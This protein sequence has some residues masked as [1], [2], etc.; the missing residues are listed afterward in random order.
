M[1]KKILVLLIILFSISGASA[2]YDPDWDYRIPVTLDN[3]G[4]VSLATHRFDVSIPAGINESSIR[5]V[6]DTSGNVVSHWAENVSSGVC[7]GLWFNGSVDSGVSEDYYIYYGNDGVASTSSYNDTF[8][9]GIVLDVPLTTRYADGNTMIDRSPYGNNGTNYGATVGADS[10]EFNGSSDYVNHGRPGS[11]TSNNISITVWLYS[12]TN[13][14]PA[15]TSALQRRGD[16]FRLGYRVTSG[17]IEFRFAIEK[18]DT[19]IIYPWLST[20]ISGVGSWHMYTITYNGEIIKVYR[21][22]GYVTQYTQTGEGVAFYT[23]VDGNFYISDPNFNFNGSISDTRIYNRALTPTQITSLYEQHNTT[24]TVTLESP[25]SSDVFVSVWNTSLTSVGSSINTSVALPLELGGTYNFD[26]YWGD[27]SFDTITSY[28][29][30]EVTHV[31]ASQGEYE[32][33]IDGT[34]NGFRFNNAGDRLKLINVTNWGNLKIGDSNGY[35]YGCNNLVITA[36]DVLYLNDTTTLF[37]AFRACSLITSIPNANDWNMSS[38]TNM[39]YVFSYA[40]LFDQDIGSWDVSSVTSMD[41]TFR[42]AETFNQD[43]GS[44]DVSNVTTMSNMFRNALA[45]DRDIG[46]WDVS[47]VTAMAYMFKYAALSTINYNSLL[48]GWE[49]LPVQNNVVFHGGYSKYSCGIVART[50]LIDDH[51]W[52]ITDGGGEVST[53]NISLYS[54]SPAT[55]FT[56]Y[57]GFLSASYMVDSNYFL[58]F[59]SLAFLMGVNYTLTSDYHSYL[60]VPPNSI[61]SDGI[62]RAHNR[63]TSPYMTWES[64]S[65]ITEGNVWKW[66]GGVNEDHWIV[67]KSVNVTHTWVNVTGVASNVFPAMFYLDRAAMY[68][69]E[70]TGIEINKGQGIILK[71]WDLE[72]FRSRNYDYYLSMFFDTQME[73]DTNCNID[74]WYCNDSF[75]PNTD[76]PCLACDYKDSWSQARWTD[77]Q[78]WQPHNNVSYSNPLQIHAG[79]VTCPS[80][81]T[82]VNYIYLQSDTVSSKS[83]I[84]NATNTDPNTCNLTFAQTNTMWTRNEVLGTN[85]P[86]AYTPSFFNTFTRDYLEFTHHLYIANDQGTWGHSDYATH[87]IGISD[88]A[89]TFCRFNYFHWNGTYD[90]C[91][92]GTYEKDFIINLTYGFDPD[93]GASL[94]HILSLY[95]DDYNFI[96]IINSSLTGNQ[97]DVNIFFDIDDYISKYLSGRYR[98]KI[99]STDNEGSTSVSWSNEFSIKRDSWFKNIVSTLTGFPSIASSILSSFLGYLPLFVGVLISGFLI[100]VCVGVFGKLKRW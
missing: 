40:T 46:P 29:Q 87:E 62:Y 68:E 64:N 25:E 49:S 27:G 93:N 65:T 76:D 20:G 51:F 35:F 79:T 58:N 98:F 8:G 39:E 82:E 67:N 23:L 31:Y 34:L 19:T 77:H 56:N 63:N 96:A 36:T 12:N 95:D 97:S 28:N 85:S 22:E 69:S 53:I 57:T 89:P 24:P 84:L 42:Y 94:T 59:S 70:K 83:F 71:V 30:A 91:M 38:V 73:A 13:N 81:P 44:W 100:M 2:W 99:V 33:V 18:P 17:N 15:K 54:K 48:M 88:I 90:Y 4:N 47:G 7:Y 21:D 26:V 60:K 32:I 6:N 37:N 74:I 16:A 92:N 66:A 50:A 43:I 86:L 45:F 3:T 9:D 55:L 1:F 78:A 10:S 72:Q 5:V 80:S 75:N 14:V 41:S 11:L 52:T 61:A